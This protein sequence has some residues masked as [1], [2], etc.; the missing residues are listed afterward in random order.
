MA[1]T[2]ALGWLEAPA[3]DSD[4]ASADHG[5]ATPSQV[6]RAAPTSA[7]EIAE[8]ERVCSQLTATW[9]P[10]ARSPRLPRQSVGRAPSSAAGT[11]RPL[12]WRAPGHLRCGGDDPR[13]EGPG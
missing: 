6:V 3:G 11:W 12:A 1:A 9:R 10:L 7:T 4:G 5:S 2:L 8:S 13:D